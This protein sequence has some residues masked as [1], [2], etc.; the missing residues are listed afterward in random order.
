MAGDGVSIEEG[1]IIN[2]EECKSCTEGHKV[3]ENPTEG[4]FTR[5]LSLALRHGSPV[6]HV[7]EQ[8]QKE[9]NSDMYSFSRVVARVLKGHIKE[10]TT[11]SQKCPSCGAKLVFAE[12]CKKCSENCGYSACS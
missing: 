11:V 4:E 7:V 9:E 6:V 5:L 10:G 3:F 8:L 1:F 12:G 2:E